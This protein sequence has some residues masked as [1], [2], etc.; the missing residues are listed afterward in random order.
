MGLSYNFNFLSIITHLTIH[1]MLDLI[2]YGTLNSWNKSPYK[3]AFFFLEVKN[4]FASTILRFLKYQC[5]G[6]NDHKYIFSY[7][8]LRLT[9]NPYVAKCEWRL[10]QKKQYDFNDQ[11]EN[12]LIL[13][14]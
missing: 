2:K 5:D 6:K 7:I 8:G 9:H 4:L 11:K 12:P 14:D 1:G 3:Y 13:Q 10:S